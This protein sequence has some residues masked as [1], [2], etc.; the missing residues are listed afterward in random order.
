MK[1]ILLIILTFG[2]F[3]PAMGADFENKNLGF[4]ISLPDNWQQ[5]PVLEANKPSSVLEGIRNGNSSEFFTFVVFPSSDPAIDET[6]L[7]SWAVNLA[8]A[9]G[10]DSK[11]IRKTEIVES[12]GN[13]W[14]ME[15]MSLDK[16]KVIT[17]HTVCNGFSYSISFL[18][19]DPRDKKFETETRDIAGSIKFY[20]PQI[21]DVVKSRITTTYSDET[22]GLFLPSQ[23]R[24]TKKPD[25][26]KCA[27]WAL[28][29]Y[30][31][32]ISAKNTEYVLVADSMHEQ[33]FAFNVVLNTTPTN[34]E[35]NQLLCK[36]VGNK[37]KSDGIKYEELFVGPWEKSPEKVFL[38]KF[39]LTR[40]DAA[41]S[42]YIF[43]CNKDDK[44][45][46]IKIQ[47]PQYFEN[48]LEE[49]FYGLIL[50]NI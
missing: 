25:P 9:L 10:Q 34:N 23:F 26:A 37:F 6:K 47:C 40:A 15:I 46:I 48:E 33:I 44:M 42:H 22:S 11:S 18:S 19:V 20:R 13:K 5:V 27:P 49:S 4:A 36:M 30:S 1:N 14:F 39:R 21:I 45:N 12:N 17:Y 2:L 24:L 32:L 3:I 43:F 29:L 31:S 7:N 35:T 28:S 8:T 41:T 50:K 38:H 16:S